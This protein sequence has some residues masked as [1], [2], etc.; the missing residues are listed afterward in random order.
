MAATKTIRSR[1]AEAASLHH[2]AGNAGVA[3]AVD[4]RPKVKQSR[5]GYDRRRDSRQARR[6]EW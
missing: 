4:T 3:V 5:K 1:N 2:R 6:E